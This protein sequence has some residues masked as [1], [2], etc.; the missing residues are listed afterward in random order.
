MLLLVLLRV[1]SEDCHPQ[2]SDISWGRDVFRVERS[3]PQ[4]L[5]LKQISTKL[6][7]IVLAVGV[8]A[9]GQYYFCLAPRYPSEES[10]QQLDK[11][12]IVPETLESCYCFCTALSH[13]MN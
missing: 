7:E 12:I 2:Q 3:T 6:S 10:N 8:S 4:H 11:L 9:V 5:D 13:I 1:G